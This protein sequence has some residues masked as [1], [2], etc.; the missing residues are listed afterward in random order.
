MDGERATG[1]ARECQFQSIIDIGSFV[2]LK[3]EESASIGMRLQIYWCL[4]IPF[5]RFFT[6][7]RFL[8]LAPSREPKGVR[9]GEVIREAISSRI[10]VSRSIS[11]E[12]SI[13]VPDTRFDS[14]SSM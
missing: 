13:L 10:E 9:V 14:G 4:L 6:F 1:R 12:F 2:G 3:A 8:N 11:I 7:V 5:W